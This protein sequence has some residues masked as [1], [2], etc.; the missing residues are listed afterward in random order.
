MAA[1]VDSTRHRGTLDSGVERRSW[2]WCGAVVVAIAGIATTAVRSGFVVRFVPGDEDV[3]TFSRAFSSVRGNDQHNSNDGDVARS[4]YNLANEFYEYGWGDSFHFGFRRRSEPHHRSIANTQNFVAQK[5]RVKDMDRVLDMGCGIGGP[6][7]GI[8]RATGANVTGIT[9][10][11]YQIKRGREITAKLAPY[12][13]ARCHFS[14]Q[15]YL[16]VKDLEENSYDAAFYMESSLHCEN[17]TQTF[18]EAFKL[19]KPGGRLVAME[20]VTIDGWDP[21]NPDLQ[22]LMRQHLHGNGAAR[23]PSVQEDLAMVRSAGFEIVEHFDYMA[24]GEQIYGEENWPWWADLQ[25]HVPHPMGMLITAHPYIRWTQPILLGAL[26]RIGILPENVARTA[27]VMNEGADGLSGL[28]KV[29]ALTPQ[30]YIGAV[31]PARRP[32]GGF[33]A[34]EGAH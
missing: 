11:A 24:L 7:R 25:P 13:Q 14:L 4:F 31:K 8:V 30:Y 23:T 3:Q 21:E 28:G 34:L 1:H 5:L 10:N 9:I 29:G 6:M 16:S 26:A 22:E 2:S 20:Y 15:D 33:S 12:M 32:L 17:R 27:A 18:K 19:L